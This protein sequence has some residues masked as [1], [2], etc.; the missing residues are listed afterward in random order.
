MQVVMPTVESDVAFGL[1]KLKLPLD[2]VRLR[3]SKSLDA[4]GML[5][6]SQVGS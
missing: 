6:Y 1:G 5:S 3:V 2:E 4:V